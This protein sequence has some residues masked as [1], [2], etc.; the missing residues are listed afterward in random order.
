MRAWRRGANVRVHGL[1]YG[2]ADP[3]WTVT[4]TAGVLR[5]ALVAGND[6]AGGASLDVV[7]D[8][9][10]LD[11]LRWRHGSFVRVPGGWKDFP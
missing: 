2:R 1:I 11:R 7:Y 10:I 8:A 4:G 5:G 9:D 3:E 6:L